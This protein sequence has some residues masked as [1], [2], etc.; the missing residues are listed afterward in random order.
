MNEYSFATAEKLM[1]LL[2]RKIWV[3]NEPKSANYALSY[4]TRHNYKG[5]IK[6]KLQNNH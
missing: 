3:M 5:K 1:L 4:E 2:L 6:Q